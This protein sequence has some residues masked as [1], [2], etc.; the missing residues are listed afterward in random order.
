MPYM[1]EGPGNLT[2]DQRRGEIAAILAGGVL[3]LHIA[4][5]QGTAHEEG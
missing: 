1:L 5:A 3:C 2:S 4:S